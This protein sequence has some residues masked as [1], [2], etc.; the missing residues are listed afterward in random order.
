MDLAMMPTAE[1]HRKL[2]TDLASERARL[3]K[4]QVVCIARHSATYQAGLAR[5]VPDVLAIANAARLRN[6]QCGFV[7][8]F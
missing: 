8:S 6:R 2:V 7:D 5:H 4:A 1:R 3:G